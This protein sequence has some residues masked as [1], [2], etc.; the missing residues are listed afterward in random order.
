MT[1]HVTEPVVG[2]TLQLR[3]PR[4]EHLNDDEYEALNCDVVGE[5]GCEACG[6]TFGYVVALCPA[7]EGETAFTW[8]NLGSAPA[9]KTWH[10][11]CCR[12]QLGQH[13]AE[14]LCS[15]A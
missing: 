10:C 11:A 1:V 14:H 4:C 8:R 2:S 9:Y 5:M 15:L 12:K 3:C 7:C 6:A 13:E